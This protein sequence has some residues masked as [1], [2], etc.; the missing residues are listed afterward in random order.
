[1]P[2][3]YTL[4]DEVN[5]REYKENSQ[6]VTGNF[7]ISCKAQ[8]HKIKTSLHQPLHPKRY[9]VKYDYR[10]LKLF[11]RNIIDPFHF[12]SHIFAVQL[13]T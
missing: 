10:N 2:H 11:Q 12:I 7:I 8:L 6:K 3:G 1:M 13:C 4:R 5:Y 9:T